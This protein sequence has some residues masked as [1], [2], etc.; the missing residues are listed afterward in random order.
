MGAEYYTK[1][2]ASKCHINF[3]VCLDNLVLMTCTVDVPLNFHSLTA[4]HKL[5]LAVVV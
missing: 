2:P 5:R 4:V 1:R 3:I